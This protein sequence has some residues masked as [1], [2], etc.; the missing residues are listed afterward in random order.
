MVEQEEAPAA[1]PGSGGAAAA[2]AAAGSAPP[3]V[4]SIPSAK[5]REEEAPIASSS[6][7]KDDPSAATSSWRIERAPA[8][9]RPQLDASSDD[10]HPDN[11]A[12][13][14]MPLEGDDVA[15]D[16]SGFAGGELGLDGT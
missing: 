5:A 16:A 1:V 3:P 15:F 10:H 8:R 2:A 6:A 13:V 14:G 12:D 11:S 7:K 4:S 9:P